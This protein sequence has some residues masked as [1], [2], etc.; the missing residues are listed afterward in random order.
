MKRYLLLVVFCIAPLLSISQPNAEDELGAWYM[1]FAKHQI[2]EKVSIN[3]GMQFRYYEPITNYN[4]NLFYTGVNYHLNSKTYFTVNY[5]YLDID[6]SIEFTDIK[7]TIE[8]RLWEQV[9]YKHTLFKIPI[10][11]RLRLE[12]RFLHNIG[13]NSIQNRIRYRLGTK[14]LFHSMFYAAINNEFFINLEGEVFRENRAYAA[15]GVKVND[16]FHFEFGYMKQHINNLHLNRL[17]LGLYLDFNW[18]TKN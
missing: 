9:Y 14:V 15:L 10:N 8:H 3:T 7:N 12:H 5:G 11:H 2:S 17:Q 13:D 16:A 4:L 1:L 6:R 18:E